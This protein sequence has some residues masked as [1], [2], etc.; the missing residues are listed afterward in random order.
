MSKYDDELAVAIAS[1]RVLRCFIHDIMVM[2]ALLEHD[3]VAFLKQA[4]SRIK[5][6]IDAAEPESATGIDGTYIKAAML[7][8]VERLIQFQAEHV[9]HILGERS[10]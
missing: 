5:S 3:P 6:I 8:E 7:T 10:A 2:S 9:S 4:E 1:I